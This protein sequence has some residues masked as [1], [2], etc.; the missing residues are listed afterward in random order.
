MPRSTNHQQPRTR[1][2]ENH[3][4]RSF[5]T[6]ADV[7]NDPD[8][9]SPLTS[10]YGTGYSRLQD[11]ECGPSGNR[12]AALG[13][14]IEGPTNYFH[15]NIP[16]RPSIHRSSTINEV[17][18][19]GTSISEP[20]G[21]ARPRNDHNTHQIIESLRRRVVEDNRQLLLPNENEGSAR[22]SFPLRPHM[23]GRWY[24]IDPF[25]PPSPPVL[26]MASARQRNVPPRPITPE[27]LSKE[28]LTISNDCKIC[29]SQHC[30]MLLLPCAHLAICEVF[31]PAFVGVNLS[32]VQGR[33]ILR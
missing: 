4:E 2:Q 16:R 3:L 32:G 21:E 26:P 6:L 5:G 1:I 31:N 17:D 23:L 11:R 12:Y 20:R 25:T 18:G 13:P 19:L 24:D 7:A 8:Y 10:L 30:N 15:T 14:P 28:E 22:E 9:I 29:F 33:L 27:P